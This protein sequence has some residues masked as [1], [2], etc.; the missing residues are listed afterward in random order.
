MSEMGWRW[1][2]VKEDLV[3]TNEGIDCFAEEE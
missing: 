1:W 2:T 3:E